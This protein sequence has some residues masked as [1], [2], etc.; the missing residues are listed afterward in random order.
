MSL[1]FNLPL[2]FQL[3]ESRFPIS[4]SA[5]ATDGLQQFRASEVGHA[6]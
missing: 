2:T 6:E 3:T 4:S 1:K 5:D